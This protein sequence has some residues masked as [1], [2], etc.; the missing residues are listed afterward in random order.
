MSSHDPSLSPKT[1]EPCCTD[2]RDNCMRVTQ[3]RSIR[4]QGIICL[5]DSGKRA[6]SENS[7]EAHDEQC[8]ILFGYLG[9]K[10]TLL[11]MNLSGQEEEEE[12]DEKL[13]CIYVITAV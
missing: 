4:S 1:D 3:H 2:Y 10:I 5:V 11:R 6:C 12:E 8:N 7:L 9:F 13:I